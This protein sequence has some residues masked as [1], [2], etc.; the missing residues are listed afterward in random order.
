MTE[1]MRALKREDGSAQV[2]EMTLLL[3]FVLAILA[4]LIYMGSYYMQSVLIYNYAQQMAIAA[5]RLAAFP[6]YEYFDGSTEITAKTDFDWVEDTLPKDNAVNTAMREHEPYRY[7]FER[8]LRDC[9]ATLEDSL[10]R[11][12]TSTSLLS[13]SSL[14]CEII[15]GGTILGKNMNVHVVKKANTP[16]VLQAIGLNSIID[17]D[18]TA[19][20]AAGDPAEFV[21]NTDMVFDLVEFMFDNLKL[22]NGKN[23]NENISIYKQKFSDTMAKLGI[24]I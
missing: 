6:G 16:Q 15:P 22:G 11:L 21:R 24:N 7:I 8:D 19:T 20:A 1:A 13:Q 18:F 14:T 2:I 10:K 9:K 23:V 5:S 17:I 12:I 3:P 4:F